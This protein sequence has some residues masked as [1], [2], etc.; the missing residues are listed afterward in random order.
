M[1][2]FQKQCTPYK[3]NVFVSVYNT[4]SYARAFEGGG[5][6]PNFQKKTFKNVFGGYSFFFFGGGGDFSLEDMFYYRE[7]YA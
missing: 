5:V 7:F 4:S 6:V 1:H 2:N 3:Y